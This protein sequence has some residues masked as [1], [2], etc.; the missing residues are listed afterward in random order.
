MNSNAFFK[1]IILI[2]S[3]FL[4][5]NRIRQETDNTERTMRERIQKADL[6]RV[7][8]EEEISRLKTVSVNEKMQAEEQLMVAKQR[9]KIEEV[10][11]KCNKY[12]KV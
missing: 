8:L 7:E 2:L 10:R 11:T 4:Q 12:C 1:N 6:Q 5:I 3:S 9:I